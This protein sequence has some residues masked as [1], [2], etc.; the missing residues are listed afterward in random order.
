MKTIT[1]KPALLLLIGALALSSALGA[2]GDD[3]GGGPGAPDAAT[4][5]AATPDAGDMTCRGPSD[6]TGSGL[7][8]LGPNQPNC[9]IPPRE[10]CADDSGCGADQ[11]CH[12]VAD[13]CSP[14][15]VGATCG[16]ACTP[17]DTSC[18]EGFECGQSGACQA[19]LCDQGFD[20]RASESCD[21][22][23]IAPDAPVADR[24]HG[25]QSITCEDDEPCPTGTFCV[26]GIC[27]DG[28]GTCTA[29]AP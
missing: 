27:Q 26:N 14:D 9:G 21:P 17:G 16:P 28:L 29:P 19:V 7:S 4:P 18:G 25:C 5:D 13:G 15:G 2:C 11:R 10:Q 1:M 3:G 24:D 12:A 22:S 23:S 20:C 6:C 8:C